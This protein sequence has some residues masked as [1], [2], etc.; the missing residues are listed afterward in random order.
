M[1]RPTRSSRYF[2]LCWF[3]L[4]VVFLRLGLGPCGLARKITRFRFERETGNWG[5][6]YGT[7]RH[8]AHQHSHHTGVSVR[9]HHNQIRVLLG[10]EFDDFF[11]PDR[12]REGRVQKALPWP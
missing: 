5:T 9:S 12:P 6:T 1:D 2:G 4:R 10:S 3:G 11:S 7:F 8:T